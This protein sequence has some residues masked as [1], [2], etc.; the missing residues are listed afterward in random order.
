MGIGERDGEERQ[1]EKKGRETK[2]EMEL[3]QCFHMKLNLE[4]IK[5]Y[6]ISLGAKDIGALEFMSEKDTICEITGKPCVLYSRG[7]SS[8]N[9]YS[10]D[11]CPSSEDI[12]EK[13]KLK[14]KKTEKAFWVDNIRR[15]EE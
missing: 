8:I 2:L 14:G 10:L 12:I 6:W 13:Y 7:N 5:K 4:N 3:H 9:Y 1:I 15:V 11:K